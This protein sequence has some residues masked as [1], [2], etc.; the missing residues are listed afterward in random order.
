MQMQAVMSRLRPTS[1]YVDPLAEAQDLA[2]LKP[3]TAAEAA[4]LEQLT[5]G[6]EAHPP[7]AAAATA[8]GQGGVC[9]QAAA[10]HYGGNAGG[11]QTGVHGKRGRC[12]YTEISA[13]SSGTGGSEPGRVTAA[14]LDKS[15]LLERLFLKQHDGK[16]QLL[17]ELQ[18]AFVTFLMGKSLESAPHCVLV[19]CLS[20]VHA[21]TQQT[22]AAVP[23]RQPL[24][25]YY[26]CLS[27]PH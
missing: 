21:T 23:R 16:A 7:A 19:A 24:G 10:A 3:A 5:H 26:A 14:N 17:G 12:R 2:L 22:C 9:A 15:E 20:H 8:S 27:C 1:G 25:V 11:A 18:F 13:V 4:M 6:R